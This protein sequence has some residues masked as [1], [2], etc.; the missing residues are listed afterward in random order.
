MMTTGEWEG[1]ALNDG[2]L[3]RRLARHGRGTPHKDGDDARQAGRAS[4]RILENHASPDGIFPPCEEQ[5]T[6][7]KKKEHFFCSCPGRAPQTEN[8]SAAPPSQARRWIRRVVSRDVQAVYFLIG[9][10]ATAVADK[11]IPLSHRRFG[12]RTGRI[13]VNADASDWLFCC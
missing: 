11:K 3:Q 2:A 7:R 1:R 6:Q 8:D 5:G 12:Q 4:S 9:T 13:S 10:E